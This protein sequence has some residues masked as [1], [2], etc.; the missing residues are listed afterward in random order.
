M[1]STTVTIIRYQDATRAITWLCE[2]FGFEVFLW[3]P[4]AGEKIEH[5]R[6]VLGDSMLMVASIGRE[7]K[8]ETK[9]KLPSSANGVTQCTSLYVE[10]PDEIYLRV[11]TSGVDIIDEIEDLEFG[12]RSFSCEDIE[13]HLWVI[14]S[15]DPW[16]KIW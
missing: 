11:K 3:V 4:G 2:T 16:K 13:S 5:S 7:G 8:F 9:F 10:N 1:K 6:L 14:S 15:H 12:G